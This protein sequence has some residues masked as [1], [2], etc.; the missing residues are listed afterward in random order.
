MRAK[1]RP[2]ADLRQRAQLVEHKFFERV[3]SHRKSLAETDNFSNVTERG[4]YSSF[5]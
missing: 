2:R 4:M 3:V 1:H 5:G